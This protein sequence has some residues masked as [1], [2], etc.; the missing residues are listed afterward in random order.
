MGRNRSIK[1]L[2][3]LSGPFVLVIGLRFLSGAEPASAPAAVAAP[4]PP[5]AAAVTAGPKLTPEQA[6]AA[7]WLATARTTAVSESPFLHLGTVEEPPDRDQPDI[8]PIVNPVSGFK[9]TGILGQGESGL[10]TINGR[11]Y[12]AG[13]KIAPGVTLVSI[14]SKHYSVQLEF[15]DGSTRTLKR[16][17]AAPKDGS[18]EPP[19][20]RP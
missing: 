20:D 18:A 9:L 4:M 12:R 19:R 15:E 5:V 14:D 10:A 11:V 6:R 2:A 13:S 7:E 17:Q 3:I 1:E 8:E 16:E